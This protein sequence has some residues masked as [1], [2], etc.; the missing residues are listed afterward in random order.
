MARFQDLK[1]F[2]TGHPDIDADHAELAEIIDAIDDAVDAEGEG[3]NCRHLLDSFIGAARRHF[4]REEDILKAAEFP[5]LE[6]HCIYHRQ[7]LEQAITVKAHCDEMLEK[8]HLRQ[9]FE[10]MARFFVDDVIRGDMEF[11]SHLQSIGMTKRR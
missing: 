8:N 4:Q 2:H 7:L 6:R 11:V 1:S 3:E 10:E 5:G 9:C